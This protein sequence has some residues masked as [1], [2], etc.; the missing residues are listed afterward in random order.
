M[1]DFQCDIL[2]QILPNSKRLCQPM[3]RVY[4]CV[5][6]TESNVISAKLSVRRPE[7]SHVFCTRAAHLKLCKFDC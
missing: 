7:I 5:D 1:I 3:D 2:N 4:S 6:L